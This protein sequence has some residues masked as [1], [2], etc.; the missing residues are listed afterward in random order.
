MEPYLSVKLP[1]E[2]ARYRA[3]V[4]HHDAPALPVGHISARIHAGRASNQ[5]R[6]WPCTFILLAPAKSTKV[7]P[8]ANANTARRGWTNCGLKSFSDVRME[9]SSPAVRR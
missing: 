1:P 4:L 3:Y 8:S 6:V 5:T 2:V 7:S 9:D